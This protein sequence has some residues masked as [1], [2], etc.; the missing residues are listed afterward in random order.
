MTKMVS[1]EKRWSKNDSTGVI[2][3]TI[4]LEAMMTAQ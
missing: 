1:K 4:P 3:M 2:P